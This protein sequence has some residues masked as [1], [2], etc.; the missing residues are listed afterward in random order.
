MLRL[1]LAPCASL[2]LSVLRAWAND[3]RGS[4][5]E[6]ARAAPLYQYLAQQGA[7]S[8]RELATAKQD[9][10]VRKAGPRPP[11]LVLPCIA[12]LEAVL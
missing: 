5:C 9:G 11:S 3:S 6:P 10:T 1:S 4:P 8:L 7:S 12:V 2:V